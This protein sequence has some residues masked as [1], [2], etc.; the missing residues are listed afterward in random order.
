MLKDFL[1]GQ[2]PHTSDLA[3]EHYGYVYS[4]DGQYPLKD[5]SKKGYAGQGMFINS[6]DKQTI[7]THHI[8]RG[9]TPK[10][11]PTSKDLFLMKRTKN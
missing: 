1:E 8:Q 5:P 3:C 11:V 9:I 6:L 4:Q 10:G 2:S 7:Y